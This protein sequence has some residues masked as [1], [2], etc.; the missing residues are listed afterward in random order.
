M[1]YAAVLEFVGFDQ[2]EG[3]TLNRT[4]KAVTT[5]EPP[6]K[7]GF[8]C[9]QIALQENHSARALTAGLCQLLW[10]EA[11]QDA[12]ASVSDSLPA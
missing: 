8:A 1:E 11:R 3:G 6:G 7:S 5:K 12:I 10:S 4:L 9:A 2:S